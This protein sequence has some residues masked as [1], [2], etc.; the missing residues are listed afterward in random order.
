MFSSDSLHALYIFPIH[1]CLS[2]FSPLML[3]LPALTVVIDQ[4]FSLA[5]SFGALSIV[6]IPHFHLFLA[7]DC[8]FQIE[9][10]NFF[11]QRKGGNSFC[12]LEQTSF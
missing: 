11:F 1:G 4:C 8:Y 5:F 10:K 6:A 9:A 7:M 2:R 3:F 12:I